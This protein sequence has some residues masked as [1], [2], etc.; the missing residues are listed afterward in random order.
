MFFTWTKEP[1]QGS[2]KGSG[3]APVTWG[4]PGYLQW[5][6]ALYLQGWGKTQMWTI[7]KAG[8]NFLRCLASVL[9]TGHKQKGDQ[10]LLAGLGPQVL[11]CWCP[12]AVTHRPVPKSLSFP[13]EVA[14]QRGPHLWSSYRVALAAGPAGT[15]SSSSYWSSPESHWLQL[16]WPLP[17]HHLPRQGY[18]ASSSSRTFSGRYCHWPVSLVCPSAEQFGL[19]KQEKTG[20]SEQSRDVVWSQMCWWVLQRKHFLFEL[21]ALSVAW[22][23]ILSSF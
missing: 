4:A 21:S 2:Q 12:Q 1:G 11:W 9:V 14:L 20:N 18:C 15:L 16:Q 17:T 8:V 19:E 3:W 10:P 5:C 6:P 22:H 23:N 7:L 13:R